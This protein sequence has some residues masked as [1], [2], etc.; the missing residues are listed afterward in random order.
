MVDVGF[1]LWDPA[2]PFPQDP[3]EARHDWLLAAH[4]NVPQIDSVTDIAM[5]DTCQHAVLVGVEK[6]VL[7]SRV[8]A[9]P[10]PGQARVRIHSVGIC[11]SDLH[12]F[13]AC[14]ST[15]STN[16]LINYQIHVSRAARSGPA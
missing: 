4:Y 13:K 15:L 5:A 16:F 3:N 2:N 7:E 9:A 11:G 10:G 8:L 14:F 12:Y 6:I 1:D